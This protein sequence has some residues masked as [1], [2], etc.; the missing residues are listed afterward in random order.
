MVPLKLHG[1]Q[2]DIVQCWILV[3]I[4]FCGIS[5]NEICKLG[6]NKMGFEWNMQAWF[7]QNGVWMKYASFGFNK[8]GLQLNMQGLVS[9]K[10]G[11]NEICKLLFQQNGVWIK[12]ANFGFN[13]MGLEWN[14]QVLVLTKWGL[15]EI[16]KLWF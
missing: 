8:M 16:C 3:Y 14:M 13:K 6:L 4:H 12:F 2:D 9:T 11:L 5:L 7:Q 10:W 15:N 1:V